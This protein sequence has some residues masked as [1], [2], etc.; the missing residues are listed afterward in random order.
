MAFELAADAAT[1]LSNGS[2]E[3]KL[4]YTCDKDNARL[5]VWGNSR[6]SIGEKVTVTVTCDGKPHRSP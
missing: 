2:V 5:E 6:E 4:T 1:V 3:V